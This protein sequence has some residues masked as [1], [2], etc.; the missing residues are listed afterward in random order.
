MTIVSGGAGRTNQY[1][2]QRAA[3]PSTMNGPSVSARSRHE[4]NDRREG[5]CNGPSFLRGGGL[6]LIERQGGRRKAEGGNPTS[7]P[8]REQKK[9]RCRKPCLH[10]LLPPSAFYL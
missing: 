10:F 3:A 6:S 8:V 7:L 1:A 2:A 9:S 5:R 4:T